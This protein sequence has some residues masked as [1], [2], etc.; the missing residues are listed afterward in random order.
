MIY[1]GVVALAFLATGSHAYSMGAPA[2]PAVARASAATMFDQEAFIQET[3]DMRLKHLEEQAMFAL[4]V[5]CENFETPVF[6]NAMIA[7]DCV[8]THLLHRMGYLKDG[9]C[10]ARAARPARPHAL[11]RSGVHGARGRDAAARRPARCYASLGVAVPPPPPTTTPP[12]PPR[13]PCTP[14]DARDGRRGVGR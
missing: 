7:G 9:R 5:S 6:P 12:P 13:A 10:K 14:P 11:A 3:K 8:I 2:R 1:S 4:K